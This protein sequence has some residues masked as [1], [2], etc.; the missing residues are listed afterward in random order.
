MKVFDENKNE[1]FDEVA[2]IAMKDVFTIID[3]KIE[4]DAMIKMT[5][6]D[7]Y[8]TIS[9]LAKISSDD[10]IINFLIKVFDECR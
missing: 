10:N 2:I 5:I 1:I 9:M 7:F 4:V 8:N 3:E 6:K